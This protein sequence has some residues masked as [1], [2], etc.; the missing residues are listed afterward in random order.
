MSIQPHLIEPDENEKKI[1]LEKRISIARALLRLR[2][3]RKHLS[4]ASLEQ[5]A[6][7]SSIQ[8]AI[9]NLELRLE[10]GF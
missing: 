9:V 1:E 2:S 7:F 10:V 6:D 4:T 3:A 5:S 8:S